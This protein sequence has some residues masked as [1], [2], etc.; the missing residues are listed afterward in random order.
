MLSSVGW[1]DPF[2]LQ[3][4][5]YDLIFARVNSAP[6]VAHIASYLGVCAVAISVFIKFRKGFIDNS[7]EMLALV[8]GALAV[9]IHEGLWIVFYYAAYGR[10]LL[11]FSL[12]PNVVVDIGFSAMCILFV[13]AYSKYRSQRLPLK[14]FYPSIV[15]YVAL[16]CI[17]FVV[18][19][20]IDPSY[21]SWL[22]ISTLNNW[23]FGQGI[24]NETQWYSAL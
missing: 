11:S 10:Y 15:G 6:N 16:L 21:Y 23:K 14:T 17:W 24:F 22:P 9:A 3:G 20:L 8:T 18:P 5:Y 4:A 13:L 7:P 12:L 1:H 19:H 2:T